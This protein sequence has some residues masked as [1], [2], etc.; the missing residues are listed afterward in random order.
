MKQVSGIARNAKLGP[1]V[2]TREGQIWILGLAEWP[3]EAVDRQVQVVGTPV[4][5]SDL[6][7][8]IHRTTG[9]ISQGIPVEPGTDL[10][11]AARRQCLESVT[12]SLLNQPAPNGEQP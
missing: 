3:S 7:V 4:E 10:Q 9:P 1:L 6:P 11:K 12:W 2:E 5:R 8:F